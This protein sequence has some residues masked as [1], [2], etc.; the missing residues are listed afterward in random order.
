MGIAFFATG[1]YDEALVHHRRSLDIRAEIKDRVGQGYSLANIGNA[2]AASGRVEEALEYHKKSVEVREGSGDVVGLVQSLENEARL[3]RELERM[4]EEM[5][6]LDRAQHLR[7]T[8]GHKA[9]GAEALA[10][11]GVL[12]KERGELAKSRRMLE[13][14]LAAAGEP[15]AAT[16]R[17]EL[18]TLPPAPAKEAERS[19]VTPP[20]RFVNGAGANGPVTFGPRSSQEKEAELPWIARAVIWLE[21]RFDSRFKSARDRN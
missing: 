14:A 15:L 20:A 2:L 16:I 18:E 19:S 17:A 5:E 12:L 3:L 9:S 6:R 8:L 13:R 4:D 1:R 11:L 7:E 10:R 21:E